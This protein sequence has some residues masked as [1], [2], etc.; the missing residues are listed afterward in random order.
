[1]ITLACVSSAPAPEDVQQAQQFLPGLFQQFLPQPSTQGDGMMKRMTKM[2]NS[3]FRLIP[4]AID[5]GMN[6]GE[7]LAGGIDNVMSSV[8][9]KKSQ[10]MTQNPIASLMGQS[11]PMKSMVMQMLVQMMSKMSP[12]DL[13]SMMM[14]M[15]SNMSLNDLMG[16]VSKMMGQMSPNGANS[17]SPVQQPSVPSIPPVPP[18][19]PVPSAVADTIKLPSE[20]MQ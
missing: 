3:P 5:G 11:D 14:Q 4:K 9:G 17:P 8:F 19:L 7:R 20:V 18:V 12:S 2:V 16:M 10:T 6:M 1:M 13:M 15:M